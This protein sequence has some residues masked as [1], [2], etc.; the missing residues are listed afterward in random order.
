MV[1]TPTNTLAASGPRPAVSHTEG[2]FCGPTTWKRPTLLPNAS[3]VGTSWRVPMGSFRPVT[4]MGPGMRAASGALPPP[5]LPHARPA[6][7]K[8][9]HP[10]PGEQIPLPGG[11][12][13]PGRLTTDSSA[14]GGPVGRSIPRPEKYQLPPAGTGRTQS[15]IT[16]MAPWGRCE[17]T[18]TPTMRGPRGLWGTNGLPSP[19]VL[20]YDPG[21]PSTCGEPPV[22]RLLAPITCGPS[23]FGG[24]P[25]VPLRGGHAPAGD[26]NLAGAVSAPAVRA[27]PPGRGR[28]SGSLM[29]FGALV[30]E[31]GAGGSCRTSVGPVGPGATP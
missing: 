14:F 31:G 3:R 11:G 18:G 5:R 10:A 28:D 22:N 26:K 2:A 25:E 1:A 16:A 29:V 21:A 15:P 13:I 6:D 7:R 20:S 8:R 23:P 4:G 27:D 9:S 17:A 30:R 24:R 12:A 19:G